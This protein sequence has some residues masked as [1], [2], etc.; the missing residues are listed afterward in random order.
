[1]TLRASIALRLTLAI[2][3]NGGVSSGGKSAFMTADIA[4]SVWL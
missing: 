1:M 2:S 4:G 3:D